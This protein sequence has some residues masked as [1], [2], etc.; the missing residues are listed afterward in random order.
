M[1]QLEPV[2]R[3][4]Q[5]DGISETLL[6]VGLVC[7]L[8]GGLFMLLAFLA[9]RRCSCP[10]ARERRRRSRR[11]TQRGGRRLSGQHSVSSASVTPSLAEDGM[12]EAETVRVPS[13]RYSC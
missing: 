7:F 12:V 13:R 1:S 10:A 8:A 6:V 11:R 4:E 5:P 2:P 9:F 3:I